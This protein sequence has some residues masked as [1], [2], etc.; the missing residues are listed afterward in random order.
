[1][2]DNNKMYRNIAFNENY[3]VFNRGNNKQE[4]FKEERDWI[5]FLFIILHFQSKITFDQI[6]RHVSH[7]VQHRMFDTDKITEIIQ[8]RYVELTSFVLM[9]NH[10]H[11]SLIETKEGGISEYLR[12]IQDAYTKYFNIKYERTGHL[13]QGPYKS[14]HIKNNE[15]LLYLSAYIHKNS[16]EITGWKDKEYLFPWSSYQDFNKNRWGDLLKSN[17]ILEQFE[18]FKEYQK[19]VKTSSAKE[20]LPD[21]LRL[22]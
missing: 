5:R 9:P 10:F 12:R 18:G 6:G 14:V 20:N 4:I 22:D 2:L 15:Q 11:L 17:I 21:K 3:H 16:K 8:N 7:Y 13:F 1:M 19:F